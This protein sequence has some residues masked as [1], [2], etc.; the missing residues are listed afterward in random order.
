MSQSRNRSQTTT[1]Q[2][3]F[4]WLYLGIPLG[5]MSLLLD[6]ANPRSTPE[7]LPVIHHNPTDRP[8]PADDVHPSTVEPPTRSSDPEPNEPFRLISIA[9]PDHEP[10]AL[11]VP[12]NIDAPRPLV[13]ALHG[14]GGRPEPHCLTWAQRTAGRAFVLCPRGHPMNS[15]LPESERGYFYDGHP[16]LGKELLAAIDALALAYATKVN[17]HD[18][19]FAGYSQGA[20]MGILFLHE[21]DAVWRYISRVVLVEG[22]S[23]EWTF[24]LAHRLKK[25]GV[26]K[27]MLACGQ[28]SCI[29]AARR[30]RSAFEKA[31]IDHRLLL[32]PGAGHTPAG[33]VG[34]AV[35]TALDWLFDGYGIAATP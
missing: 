17:V 27:L 22:G 34:A 10:A 29:R 8:R 6:C 23:S 13:V 33:E 1:R 11:I 31:Q 20:T 24:A 32:I 18:A 7:P 14:A 9:V 15:H 25:K 26:K 5:W 21:N 3:R 16:R 2:R 19:T 12:A 4:A 35:D 28:D 30:W